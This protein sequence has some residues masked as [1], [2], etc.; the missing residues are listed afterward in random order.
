MCHERCRASS[1]QSQPIIED[2]KRWRDLAAFV[3]LEKRKGSIVDGEPLLLPPQL[4][5]YNSRDVLSPEDETETR[6]LS[7][8]AMFDY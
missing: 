6:A 4:S 1:N 3:A 2:S 7:S 5:K 8:S